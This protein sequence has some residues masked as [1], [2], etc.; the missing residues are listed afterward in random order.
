M[1][2][3]GTE[4]IERGI[5][6]N[7]SSNAVQMQGVDVR[8]DNVYI[9]APFDTI[10]EAGFVPKEGKTIL[11]KR[12]KVL[13]DNKD[14]Q[15]IFILFPGYYEIDLMEGANIPSNVSLHFKTR[16]SVVRCGA[17]VFSGQFD[18]GFHTQKAGCFLKVFKP[19]KIERGA[20]IAQAICFESA[21]VIECYTGQWQGQ[22]VIKDK[23]YANYK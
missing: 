17:V 18:A 14:N 11:P 21:E 2:L 8:I 12:I 20:R 3:T 16:S 22:P 19:I 23:T 7:H 6:F 4:I 10:T 9:V 15:E 13:P 5:V 1:Q